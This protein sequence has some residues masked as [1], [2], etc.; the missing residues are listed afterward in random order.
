MSEAI[1]TIDTIGTA[2]AVDAIDADDATDT[3][4]AVGN[5]KHYSRKAGGWLGTLL[6]AALACITVSTAT[7][8]FAIT[9]VLSGS[10][11]PD[12]QPGDAMFAQRVSANSLH[13][14]DI[15]NIKVPPQQGG[16]QRVHRIVAIRH[17][18]TD[19]AIRTRGDANSSGDPGWF[20][21]KGKQYRTV[22]RLPW[23][24]WLTDFRAANG[25]LLLVAA[26]AILG[27]VSLLQRLRGR[28]RQVANALDAL[29]TSLEHH[30]AS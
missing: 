10:M 2:D 5:P 1:D 11:R 9:P 12:F 25:G 26:V 15:V 19:V 20:V 17:Q 28:R 29:P 22:A 16:G 21:L 30:L 7:G 23:V 6:L 13:V 18:G 8:W 4:E 24:G 3:N 27:V 14:G